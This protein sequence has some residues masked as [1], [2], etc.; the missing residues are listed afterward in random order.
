[1]QSPCCA[2]EDPLTCL[3]ARRPNGIPDHSDHDDDDGD[4]DDHHPDDHDRN[5]H[6]YPDGRD[7]HNSASYIFLLHQFAKYPI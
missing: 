4:P 7:N 6:D 1:M 5:D 3:S 2:S